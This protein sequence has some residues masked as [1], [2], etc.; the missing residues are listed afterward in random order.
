MAYFMQRCSTLEN[1]KHLVEHGTRIDD[2]IFYKNAMCTEHAK[3]I[4]YM[5]EVKEARKER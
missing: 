5:N 2:S 3:I 4:Q 1:V